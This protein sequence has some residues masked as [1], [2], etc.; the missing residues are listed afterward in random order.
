MWLFRL[1]ERIAPPASAIP[2]AE[3]A[4][5]Y[6]MYSR[7]AGADG[8]TVEQLRFS[9]AAE[10]AAWRSGHAGSSPGSAPA[11]ARRWWTWAATRRPSGPAGTSSP[12]R[13]QGVNGRGAVAVYCLAQ[14]LWRRGELAEAAELGAARAAGV[15]STRPS[16][17][18]AAW[19][20]CSAWSRCPA[21]T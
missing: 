19:T 16:A 18:G 13:G 12:G 17:A 11:G 6:H 2:D 10:E 1:Y 4:V 15:D 21:A 7:H 9:S 8:E 20:C 14:L 5:A 3:L